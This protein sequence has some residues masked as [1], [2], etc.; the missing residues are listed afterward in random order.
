MWDSDVIGVMDSDGQHQTEDMRR[1][2]EFADNHRKTLVLG[3]KECRQR[4]A[5][6]IQN[7]KQNNKNS[8]PPD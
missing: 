5:V 6:K 7:R 4:N 1:V 3:V 2:L 8:F